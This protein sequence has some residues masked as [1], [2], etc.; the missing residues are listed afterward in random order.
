MSD[1]L[2]RAEGDAI[3]RALEELRSAMSGNGA[4]VSVGVQDPRFSKAIN[5]VWALIGVVLIGM[6]GWAIHS[7]D[8]LN[9][10]VGV[11]ISQNSSLERRVEA[12]ERRP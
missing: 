3:L 6:L 11:L 7:I 10:K 9:V 1:H 5:S 2:T 4:R 8:D 12:L